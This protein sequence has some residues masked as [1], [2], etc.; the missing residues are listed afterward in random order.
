MKLFL[1]EDT[2]QIKTFYYVNVKNT[3]LASVGKAYSYTVIVDI[4]ADCTRKYAG[5]KCSLNCFKKDAG[6][7]RMLTL[8]MGVQRRYGYR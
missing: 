3:M 2:C 6:S 1:L 7:L 4:I 5:R 8:E